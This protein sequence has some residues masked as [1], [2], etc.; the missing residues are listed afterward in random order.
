[1]R[2]A[3][4]VLHYFYPTSD[5]LTDHAQQMCLAWPVCL[6]PDQWD[7]PDCSDAPIQS[8]GCRHASPPP[9]S[10]SQIVSSCLIVTVF[11]GGCLQCQPDLQDFLLV[12]VLAVLFS[13][14]SHLVEYYR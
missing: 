4:T 3:P 14:K 2:L 8:Q 10:F 9:Q 12:V 6:V 7:L 5:L 11:S 1:M 13:P